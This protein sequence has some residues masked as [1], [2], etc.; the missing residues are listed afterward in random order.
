MSTVRSGT[1]GAGETPAAEQ[2]LTGETSG[3]PWKRA[4]CQGRIHTAGTQTD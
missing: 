3:C 2:H 4:E 1:K